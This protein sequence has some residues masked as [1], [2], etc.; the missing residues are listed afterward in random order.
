MMLPTDMILAWDPNFRAYLE[1]YAADEAR[2]KDDFGRAFKKLTEL[3][4]GFS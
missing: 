3:G 2:L 4:C 1:M